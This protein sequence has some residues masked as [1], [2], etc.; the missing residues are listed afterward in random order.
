MAGA[1]TLLPTKVNLTPQG[2][3]AADEIINAG[4]LVGA[5]PKEIIGGLAG[6]LAETGGTLDKYKVGDKGAAIGVF[7]QHDSYGTLTQRLDVTTAAKAFFT[8]LIGTRDRTGV[9]AE[10]GTRIA[11]VQRPAA[12][13]RHIYGDNLDEALYVFNREVG[14]TTLVGAKDPGIK[15]PANIYATTGDGGSPARSPSETAADGTSGSSGGTDIGPVA[16]VASKK[17]AGDAGT[18]LALSI[19]TT[20]D[21][22]L[23]NTGGALDLKGASLTVMARTG[24]VA[25]GVL[26][27]V[28]GGVLLISAILDSGATRQVTRA[29]SII[30]G[31]AGGVAAAEVLAGKTGKENERVARERGLLGSAGGRSGTLGRREEMFPE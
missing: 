16:L 3:K 11:D 1:V 23:N 19:L 26:L 14:N 18:G 22:A 2:A 20:I 28:S 4:V 27:G 8:R 29:A 24:A 21:D 17:P 7:Q 6:A 31:A 12:E 5:T 13:Y 9:T 10:L 30:P 25:I 15:E